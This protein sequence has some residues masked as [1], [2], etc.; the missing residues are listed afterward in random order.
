MLTWVFKSHE[1]LRRKERLRPG[2]GAWLQSTISDR[3]SDLYG[4]NTAERCRDLQGVAVDMLVFY[5]FFLHI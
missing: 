1:S 5:S 4:S 3:G 2:T